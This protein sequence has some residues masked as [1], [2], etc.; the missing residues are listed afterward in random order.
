[1]QSV[2]YRVPVVRLDS[3]QG[4]GGEK[5][6][7]EGW[8]WWTAGLDR[9]GLP[10]YGGEQFHRTQRGRVLG[11]RIANYQAYPANWRRVDQ[12]ADEHPGG[13]GD[14]GEQGDDGDADARRDER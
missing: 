1:M 14:R 6:E 3:Q 4:G 8:R 9:R 10:R 2:T 13:Q 5:S 7:A 11:H 12:R